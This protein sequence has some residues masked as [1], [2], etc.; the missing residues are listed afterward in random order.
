MRKKQKEKDVYGKLQ[1]KEKGK[2]KEKSI[3]EKNILEGKR[4][5]YTNVKKAREKINQKKMLN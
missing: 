4:L 3:K 1:K 5:E 2:L